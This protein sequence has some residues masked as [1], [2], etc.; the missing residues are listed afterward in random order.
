MQACAIDT[1]SHVVSAQPNRTTLGA[2]VKAICRAMDAAGCDS[3]AELAVAGLRLESLNGP[4]V[5]CPAEL[6]IRLWK[7]AMEVTRDPAFGVKAASYIKNTSFQALSYGVASSSTLKEA[8]ERSM[9]YSRWVSDFVTYQ[10][11]RRGPEYHFVM[12][13]TIEVPDISV[14]CLAGLYLRMCRSL[15]WTRILAV[16]HRAAATR[17]GRARGL[18]CTPSNRRYSSTRQ[19]TAW[20]SLRRAWSVGS[21]RAIRN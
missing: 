8:F 6:S 16:T 12:E 2:W 14:D 11:V 19:R 1:S 7:R 18:Q 5:R 21:M 20:F 3:R 13:P 4:H 9:R 17:P 15:I 10:L